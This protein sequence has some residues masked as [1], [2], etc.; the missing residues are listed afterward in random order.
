M[1]LGT[2]ALF[3][4]VL[5]FIVSGYLRAIFLLNSTY[6]VQVEQNRNTNNFVILQASH[7]VIRFTLDLH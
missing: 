5:D 4:R 1:S 3:S 7:I 2:I 6:A